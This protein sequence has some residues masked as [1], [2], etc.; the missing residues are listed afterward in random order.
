MPISPY[1]GYTAGS[2]WIRANQPVVVTNVTAL[3]ALDKTEISYAVT[4]GYYT[5]GDGGAGEYWYDSSDTT[6]TDNG[7]SVI[8]GSDGG[9]WKLRIY[10][11]ELIAA[12]FGVDTTGVTDSS[13]QLQKCFSYI[14]SQN[15][16][17]TV[18]L[19]GKVKLTSSFSIDPQH[20]SIKLDNCEI[21]Y[22][23]ITATTAF[24]VQGTQS[25][26]DWWQRKKSV[27]F[28]NGIISGPGSTSGKTCLFL[29]STTAIGSSHIEFENIYFVNWGVGVKISNN[30]YIINF[31]N[32]LL[33]RN[34]VAVQ[35]PSGGTNCG[36]RITF[37]GC[38]IS[39]NTLAFQ[40][41]VAGGNFHLVSSS[42]DFNTKHFELTG[43]A[44]AYLVG[45]HVEGNDYPGISPITLSGSG[46]TFRMDSGVIT[47]L[48]AT[49]Q[50]HNSIIDLDSSSFASFTGVFLNNIKNTSNTFSTGAG[51]I[52][53]SSLSNFSATTGL[54]NF[55]SSDPASSLLSDPSFTNSV[56]QDDWEISQDT[57]V[58]SSPTTGT[59]I[60]ISQHA[61]GHSG[62]FSLR[63]S[64]T[65]ASANGAFL[66]VSPN[67]GISSKKAFKFWYNKPS[68]YSV[69]GNLYVFMYHAIAEH[70]TNGVLKIK[71]KKS[72]GG[73]TIP[74]SASL[75]SGWTQSADIAP[76]VL[77]PNWSTHTLVEFNMYDFGGAVLDISDCVF[78]WM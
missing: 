59:N 39:D 2:N 9:R 16:A 6:S 55:L 51:T 54:P 12:Q 62:S 33:R 44:G 34:G 13:S 15:S 69:G 46:T 58:I 57:S 45:C 42:V 66:I 8:V 11:T 63:A 43:G 36:E 53:A 28:G 71:Y 70:D 7:G 72:L 76:G 47:G 26:V 4:K 30:S 17:Y 38:C 18:I 68:T 27:I 60:S 14:T 74:L 19:S 21:D 50:S 10:N 22:T 35:I 77:S 23:G 25:G 31:T 48:A 52:S 1:D 40:G 73:I 67:N 75:I 64:K 20:I 3:R 29:Y 78:S 56:L 37:I 61:G 65:S 24:T 41:A 49:P 32:C 5:A